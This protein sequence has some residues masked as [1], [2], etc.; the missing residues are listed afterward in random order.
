LDKYD[1][2]EVLGQGAFGIVHRARLKGSQKD[3]AVKMVD[4]VE[5][6]RADID[7][8]IAMMRKLTGPCIVKIFETFPEKVF[9]CLVLELH[10][11]GDM[12]AG[13]CSYWKSK[14]MIPIPAVRN[15]SKQMWQ[16][17]AFVHSRGCVHR[18]I[19]GDNFLMETPSVD[20][21]NNRIYLSDFGT[22]CDI[23]RGQRL[24]GKCGTSNY[25]SPEFYDKNYGHKVDNWATG[26]V[27]F[28]LTSGKFPFK[29][30]SDTRTKVVA[31]PKRC[32]S[33]G[34]D[35]IKRVLDRKEERRW[36]ASQAVQHKFFDGVATSAPVSVV[37]D[38]AQFTPEVR[39]RG[40]NGGVQLRRAEL[41]RRLQSAAEAP[42]RDRRRSS[43]YSGV[44][45]LAEKFDGGY[46]VA[47]PGLKRRMTYAWWSPTKA[48]ELCREFGGAERMRDTNIHP[49][50]LSNEAIAKLLTDHNVSLNGFG[51][52]RA[53]SFEEF[54]DEVRSGKLRL[55]LD[56][57]RHKHIVCVED[58]VCV[59][60][61]VTEALG[62]KFLVRQSD[63]APNS[64]GPSYELPS[65]DKL[66]H[67]STVVSAR[68]LLQRLKLDGLSVNFDCS[69]IESTEDIQES[70]LYPGVPMVFLKE[71]VTG[72]ASG[73]ITASITEDGS[74]HSRRGPVR[75]AWL[76][77]VQ[78]NDPQITGESKAGADFSTLVYP[79]IG[80]E[81]DELLRYLQ[82]SLIDTDRWGTG[83]ARSVHEFAEELVKGEA[84]L[85]KMPNGQVK[86]IVD[87][88]IVK[89][90]RRGAQ[91]V[92]VEL[93]ETVKD[94]R[95]DLRRLPAVKRRSDEHQFLAARRLITQFLRLNENFVRLDTSDVRV[96]EE[97][98]QS[99][100]Y[101]GL[102]TVYR[103]RY[104]R[105]V[106]DDDVFLEES[107]SPSSR[108]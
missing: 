89:L 28:G 7:R 12:I 93:E 45:R 50:E 44:V 78:V 100:S 35:L 19:K 73:V 67:E 48:D 34:V 96:V 94:S 108:R 33:D 99:V 1:L 104:L 88:V 42:R 65:I 32:P 105:A 29:N 14:G 79:P 87:V 61:C 56:A 72:E 92:L 103:K 63:L 54:A 85:Q 6:S 47:D 83:T 39:E 71:I 49:T 18:D 8:E 68:R 4:C 21:L 13:M 70:Q 86:R 31:V 17:V 51:R 52:G 57:S 41:V 102:A 64:R 74:P 24:S 80:L 26:V 107:P 23:A 59:R 30:E 40:A 91:D 16:A 98:K 5:T 69:H 95:Q 97:E 106:L 55:Q 75:Y 9:V 15:L 66:P 53:R 60:L 58:V 2:H 3:F 20:D 27:M 11:G 84:T 36:E 43:I 46:V 101:P 81:E 22:V 37:E 10:K 25:W 38:E 82:T 90:V 77:P 76:S 62:R